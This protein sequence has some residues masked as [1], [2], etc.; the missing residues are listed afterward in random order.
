V[1]PKLGVLIPLLALCLGACG[2]CASANNSPPSSTPRY[3]FVNVTPIAPP[4]LYQKWYVEA[5]ACS[6]TIGIPFGMVQWFVVDSIIPKKPP[7][8]RL[9]GIVTAGIHWRG[10][11]Y[12]LKGHQ[13]NETLIKHEL[14]HFMGHQHF[15]TALWRCEVPGS[16]GRQCERTG[17]ESIGSSGDRPTARGK[18]SVD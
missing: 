14:L 9:P 18:D 15:H 3:R 1:I 5:A 12:V 13:W 6:G 11:I 16:T 10:S 8:N 4:Q 17:V 2:A 7:P